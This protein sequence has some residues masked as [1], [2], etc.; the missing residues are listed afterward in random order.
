M[1]YFPTSQLLKPWTCCCH[2]LCAERVPWGGCCWGILADPPK[3]MK[4]PS[5]KRFFPKSQRF[6]DQEEI[7]TTEKL[8]TGTYEKGF[9]DTGYSLAPR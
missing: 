4:I 3:G 9:G 6:T 2:P 5:L 8:L 7:L 1:I